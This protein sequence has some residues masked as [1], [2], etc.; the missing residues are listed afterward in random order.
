VGNGVDVDAADRES[1]QQVRVDEPLGVVFG[2]V[3]LGLKRGAFGLEFRTA[4]V[5]V[6]DQ[7]LMA[8]RSAPTRC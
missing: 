6:A 8:R 3:K 4:F 2:L 5:D 1:V 7:L